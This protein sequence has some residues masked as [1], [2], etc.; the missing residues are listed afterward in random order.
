MKLIS[1]DKTSQ[2]V[3]G[4]TEQAGARLNGLRPCKLARTVIKEKEER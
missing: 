4:A 3:L 2:G 1:R